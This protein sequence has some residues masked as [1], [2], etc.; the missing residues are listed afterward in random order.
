MAPKSQGKG[1]IDSPYDAGRP[2]P[3]VKGGPGEYNRNPQ[4][5][6]AGV[7]GGFPLKFTDD[8]VKTPKG[9]LIPQMDV[10]PGATEQA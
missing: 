4:C 1:T 9:R 8:S 5:G 3:G 6:P 2:T 7:E 10:T